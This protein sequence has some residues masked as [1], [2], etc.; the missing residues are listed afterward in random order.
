MGTLNGI[1]RRRAVTIGAAAAALPLVHIRTGRAA[2]DQGLDQIDASPGRRA[3]NPKS[4]RHRGNSI[5]A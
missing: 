5:A 4:D 2:G 3:N 1:S